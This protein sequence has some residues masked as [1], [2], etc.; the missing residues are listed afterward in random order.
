MTSVAASRRP[1]CVREGVPGVLGPSE[2][3]AT[4]RI[5]T[6]LLGSVCLRV[7]IYCLVSQLISGISSYNREVDQEYDKLSRSLAVDTPVSN[8]GDQ[9]ILEN[10]EITRA[11]TEYLTSPI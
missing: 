4:F 8:D 7:Q 2:G 9:K 1:G 5:S 10:M 6:I 11:S 3:S